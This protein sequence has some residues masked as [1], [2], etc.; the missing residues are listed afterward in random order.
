M[1]NCVSIITAR[2]GSKRI[3]RKN[4][5]NFLGS[6]IIKY[7]IDAALNAKCFDEVMVSTEDN[8]I[9]DL[10][11]FYG[12]KIPFMRTANTSND[13]AA[14]VDVILEVLTQYKLQGKEFKY[15]CCIYP[16]A[17]FITSEKLK[18]A[19]NKLIESGA[20]SI[21]P[22]VRF[23]FPIQRS[24][25]I[26]DG[27]VKMNWPEHLNSRSQDLPPAF[28][29]CGQFYFFKVDSFLENKILFSG[30]TVPYEMPE[31]EVQDIDNEEDWK[32]AELK[33]KLMIS[34]DRNNKLWNG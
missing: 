26:E 2:G 32:I 24:I 7:S 29:D 28:H 14:T 18:I 3:P 27:L 34:N 5:K 17:P 33:Y 15:C 12:A 11:K 25:K 16:T 19:Y 31:S 22:V 1:N 8:E 10:A 13:F 21:V 6:P 4:I 30:F 23:G 9:A 20:D